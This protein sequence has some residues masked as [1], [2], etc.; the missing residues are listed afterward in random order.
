MPPPAHAP[1][2]DIIFAWVGVYDDVLAAAY[3]VYGS[4]QGSDDARYLRCW[5]LT[6]GKA[7][8]ADKLV[9]RGWG[10]CGGQG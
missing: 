4:K 7:M 8:Q 10:G 9:V 3:N 5:D 6:T 2:V 1:A